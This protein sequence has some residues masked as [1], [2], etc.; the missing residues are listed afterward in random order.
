M[1]SHFPLFSARNADITQIAA[2]TDNNGD[3]CKYVIPRG[4]TIPTKIVELTRI[5]LKAGEMYSDGKKVEGFPTRSALISFIDYLPQNSLLVGHNMHRFDAQR[6]IYQLQV[7]GL[8]AEF[9][10]KVSGFLDTYPLAQELYP[11]RKIYKQTALV[12]DLLGVE[13]SAHNAVDDV[14]VL[15]QLL[16]HMKSSTN[17]NVIRKHTLNFQSTT[18]PPRALLI[19]SPELSEDRCPL[20]N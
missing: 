19:N 1:M 12:Q 15:K 5:E 18:L 17:S 20:Y 8:M 3:F 2:T 13:Y 4:G 16:Q 11:E 9:E 14:K 10:R 7:E 6:L